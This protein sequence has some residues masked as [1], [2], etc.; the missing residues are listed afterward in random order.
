MLI[1]QL[2]L[3]PNAIRGASEEAVQER[4]LCRDVPAI[5]VVPLCKTKDWATVSWMKD[6]PLDKVQLVQ[7]KS[8]LLETIFAHGCGM[9]VVCF[10]QT[11]EGLAFLS[12]LLRF[13]A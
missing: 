5:D 2:L 7:Y 4:D 1:H 9:P 8:F 10:A 3:A 11:L 12:G 13:G 6:R